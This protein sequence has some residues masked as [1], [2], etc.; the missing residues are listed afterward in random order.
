MKYITSDLHF[1]HKAILKICPT[2]RQCGDMDTMIEDFIDYH[3]TIVR[4]QD[5]LY[6]LGDFSFG[7][8]G[9]T[10]DILRQMQGKKVIVRGNHDQWL[11][12]AKPH[13]L[14]EVGVIE[15]RDLMTVRHEGRKIVMCHYALR[16]WNGQGRGTLHAFGHSHGSLEGFGRSMDV[17]W[18]AVGRYLMLDEVVDKLEGKEIEVADHHKV[19][20]C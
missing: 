18:D 12:K 17:G 4:P 9:P 5:T 19:I 2:H 3:N 13:E 7:K 14:K 8:A 11:D 1:F 6:I 15:V 16:A 10:L 20:V